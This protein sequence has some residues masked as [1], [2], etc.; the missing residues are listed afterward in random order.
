M[1]LLSIPR[2]YYIVSEKIYNFMVFQLI[3]NFK[4]KKKNDI[5]RALPQYT[6]ASTKENDKCSRIIG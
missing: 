3:S 5:L 2:T 6:L 4:K 1:T